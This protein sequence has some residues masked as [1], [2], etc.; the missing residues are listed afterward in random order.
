M[1]HKVDEVFTEVMR[2]VVYR[3]ISKWHSEG[4]I[5]IGPHTAVGYLVQLLGY[6]S[7]GEMLRDYNTKDV[8]TIRA[9]AGPHGYTLLR[10]MLIRRSK[11]D[12]K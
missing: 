8:D 7:V 9:L 11:D 1:E 4:K 6:E 5:N 3:N 10:A 12:I 2:S